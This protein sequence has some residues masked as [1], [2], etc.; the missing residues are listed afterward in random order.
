MAAAPQQAPQS[1]RRD[2]MRSSRSY[3]SGGGSGKFLAIFLGVIVLLV[4][5][6]A[7]LYLVK[8]DETTKMTRKNKQLEDIR[9]QNIDRAYQAYQRA[10]SV[11][12]NFVTGRDPMASDDTLFGPF[13]GD[14]N[15][16]N[17]VYTRN[18]KDKARDTFTQKMMD[19]SRGNIG[20]AASG[21]MKDGINIKKGKANGGADPI[22]TARKSYP[23]DPADKVNQGGEIFVIVTAIPE[24]E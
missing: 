21:I 15:I 16:Y 9:Q 3:G 17:V 8:S 23:N 14:P 1:Q 6:C 24:P 10:H 18:Y 2:S 4:G 5:I 20:E 19:K 13:R 22:M 12:L 7:A 11:G